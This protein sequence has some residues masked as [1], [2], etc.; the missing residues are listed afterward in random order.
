MGLDA[1]LFEDEGVLLSRGCGS[2]PWMFPFV[3]YDHEFTNY[4]YRRADKTRRTPGK[5]HV[6]GSWVGQSI[7][8]ACI[9]S[10]VPGIW[11]GYDANYLVCDPFDSR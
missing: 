4:I 7:E 5:V 6:E 9:E 2:S 1:F 11:N 8:D 10:E 3:T